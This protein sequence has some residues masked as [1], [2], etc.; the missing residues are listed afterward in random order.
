L[1]WAYTAEPFSVVWAVRSDGK[2]LAFTWQQ[3]HQVWGWTLCETDGTVESVCS[4]SEFG[5]DR[6]YLTV[7]RIIGGVSRLFIERMASA[8]TDSI[9]STCYMDCAVS[10]SFTNLETHFTGLDHLNGKAVVAIAD[11]AVVDG[12]TVANGAV[13]LPDGARIV[14]IGFRSPRRSKPFRWLFRRRRADGRSPSRSRGQM[15]F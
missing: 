11:G 8:L 6:L 10:Y 9:P 5:E 7:R 12:L 15:S 4:V 3:E 14:T 1:S 13:T 2:L